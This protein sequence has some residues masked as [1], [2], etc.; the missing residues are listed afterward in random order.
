MDPMLPA[1]P[2]AGHDGMTNREEGYVHFMAREGRTV[3]RWAG[4]IALVLTVITMVSPFWMAAII[5]A[6]IMIVSYVLLI[7]TNEVERRS[8]VVAHDRL[9]QS[10]T[11]LDR[12]VIDDHAE[13]DQVSEVPTAIIKRE[14][15]RGFIVLACLL[16][17]ALIFAYVKLPWE[18]F[19]IGTFVV[20]CY[21]IFIMAPVW[22]GWFENDI[23]LQQNQLENKPESAQVRTS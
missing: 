8:D 19:A 1:T 21:M 9:E 18:V 7:L 4:G 10:E 20:F 12:D 14:S 15:K 11:A 23:E 5:P 2:D 16:V 6:A 3:L 22:L 17:A 13:D